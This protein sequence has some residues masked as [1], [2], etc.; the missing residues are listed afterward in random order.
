MSPENLNNLLG[1]GIS[2][3]LV[4]IVMIVFTLIW[5][6]LLVA[7]CYF[8]S[9]VLKRIPEVH[10]KMQPGLV[11]LLLIPCFGMVWNF[12]VV[13]QIPQ[14]L[15]SY[16]QSVG[17]TDVG[18]CGFVLGLISAILLALGM[19]PY[20]GCIFSIASLILLIIFV[21]KLSALK[22]QLPSLVYT[23]Q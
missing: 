5:I 12:F 10:R 4:I 21:V 15:Q 6:G 13:I 1:G 22:Q 2:L 17:R 8:Y 14:S 19:I 7:L 3:V 9:T 18:D 20:I 16:F 11:W 23:S